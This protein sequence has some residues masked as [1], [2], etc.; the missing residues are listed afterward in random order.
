MEMPI[1]GSATATQMHSRVHPARFVAFSAVD[2][3]PADR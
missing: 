3:M 1:M 2:C